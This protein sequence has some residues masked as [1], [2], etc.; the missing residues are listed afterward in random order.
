M[1]NPTGRARPHWARTA[2]LLALGVALTAAIAWSA[3]LVASPGNVE[4]PREV[5]QPSYPVTAPG[6]LA[7]TV[8]PSPPA[9]P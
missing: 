9:R 5:Y 7:P 6:W 1:Y 3:A 4:L 8:P 2:F